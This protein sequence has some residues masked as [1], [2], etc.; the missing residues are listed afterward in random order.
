MRCHQVDTRSVVRNKEPQSP[1]TVP[2]KVGCQSI[3]KADDRY[4]SL[5]TT[6]VTDQCE[7]GTQVF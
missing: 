1:F 4:H 2:P 7:T 3:R 6:P 5:F